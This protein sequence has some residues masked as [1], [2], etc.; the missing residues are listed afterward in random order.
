MDYKLRIKEAFDRI[1]EIWDRV[2]RQPWKD[3]VDYM[4][5]HQFLNNC[6]IILDIGCGNGRHTDLMADDC[7][8]SIGLEISSELLKFAKQNY[9][10]NNIYY[11][12]SDAL[13]LPF[14]DNIFSKIIYIATLH[15]IQGENQR[16]KSL[17]ELKRVLKP[18]GKGIIT[19]WRRFQKNFFPI[20]LIDF[21]F[22][23]FLNK[24]LEFGDIFV[25]WH[26]P[27]KKILAN[28]FYHL[29][30]MSEMKKILK[31]VDIKIL[32]CR[33]FSGKTKDENLITLIMKNK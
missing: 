18:S 9:K 14:R 3:L 27:D 26:G 2:R 23:T 21:F 15:H 5:N 28:R 10:K 7:K 32:E 17:F 31:K 11:I 1:S 33:Y 8:L 30:T 16:V 12:N 25:P 24:N 4:E 20:F 22:M 19:V 6:D 13:N 29:F